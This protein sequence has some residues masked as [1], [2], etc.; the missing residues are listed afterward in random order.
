MLRLVGCG[1]LVA[2]SSLLGLPT[3]A[4]TSADRQL[5]SVH[6]EAVRA[7][8][9][10]PWNAYVDTGS[11]ICSGAVIDLARVLTAA[12]CVVSGGE[13]DAPQSM[14]IVA[15]VVRASFGSAASTGQSRSV[16]AV[17]VH[18]G[19]RARRYRLAGRRSEGGLSFAYDLAVLTLSR[20]L[21]LTAQVSPV[22]MAAAPARAGASVRVI[23]W[24]DPAFNAYEDPSIARSMTA[25]TVR[26]TL[27]ADGNPSLL[28]MVSR[29][30]S[31]CSGDS[32]AGVVT[33]A[34]VPTL[35]AIHS[36]HDGKCVVGQ[37][38]G[39]TSTTDPGVALWLG[40]M[41]RPALAPS[42]SSR[43]TIALLKGPGRVVCRG[44]SWR[45]ATKVRT[46]FVDDRTQRTLQHGSRVFRPTG[47]TRRLNI[48]CAS[49]ATNAAGV[50]ESSSSRALRLRIRQGR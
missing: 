36:F 16:S 43:P 23:G 22:A 37:A 6:G 17:Q 34:A 27:C 12:A 8:S 50:T 25:R 28:C 15:G 3:I 19:F 39:A 35:V 38:S 26:P 40:G 1:A 5:R 11:G 44:P 30:Q 45:G 42:T 20:P 9:A 24:G 29:R 13:V 47:P 10:A 49:I 41:A 14:T 21:D 18:P 48:Y 33:A 4:A 31:P 7:P 46:D 32:G 2:A